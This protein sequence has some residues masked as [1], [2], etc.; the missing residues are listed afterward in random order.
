VQTFHIGESRGAYSLAFSPDGLYLGV[1]SIPYTILDTTGRNP[2]EKI[3]L[4]KYAWGYCFVRGGQRL[5]YLTDGRELGFHDRDTGKTVTRRFQRGFARDLVTS[6][7]GKALYMIVWPDGRHSAN[8]ILSEVWMLDPGTMHRRAAF[9][10]HP[11]I[12]ER[13]AVSADGSRLA[14]YEGG[15]VDRFIRVW[16]IA[17]GKLPKRAVVRVKPRIQVDRF[18][19]SCNG[20]RLA[21]VSS[22]G[23]TIWDTKS[24]E[25]VIHSGKHRR[26][27][28]AVACSPNRPTLV[29]GDNAGKVFLWDTAGR[30]LKRYDWGLSNVYHVAFAPDGLRA[31]AVDAT[32]KVV[33]WDV[34]V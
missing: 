1:G 22:R 15:P 2:P 4:A 33:V 3:K 23:L 32:G 25:E 28:T 31:A 24:G 11:G 18:A 19:L 10:R 21:A 13:L 6:A 5:V 30:V 29:T 9:A 27:V 7:D 17:G 34:D 20:S 12:S 14:T 26:S 16:N 8:R